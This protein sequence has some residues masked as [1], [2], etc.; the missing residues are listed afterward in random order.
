MRVILPKRTSILAKALLPHLE[1]NVNIRSFLSLILKSIALAT[2][3]AAG[4][5]S[6]L[7]TGS[8]NAL[9]TLL[10]IGLTCLALRALQKDQ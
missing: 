8:A 4:V 1:V 6:I 5:L 10:G 2:G 7:G 9:I 3:V